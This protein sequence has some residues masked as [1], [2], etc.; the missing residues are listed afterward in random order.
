MVPSFPSSLVNEEMQWNASQEFAAENYMMPM[1]PAFNPYWSSMQPG[2]EGFGA[3]FAGPMPYMG[4]GLGPMPMDFPYGGHFPQDPYGPPV[5][6]MPFPPQRYSYL[7][8]LICFSRNIVQRFFYHLYLFHPVSRIRFFRGN[9][10]LLLD[11][12]L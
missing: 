12:Y 1:G 8:L 2:M 3:P 4:Y 6:M 7:L 9:V 10:C 5:N 11:C